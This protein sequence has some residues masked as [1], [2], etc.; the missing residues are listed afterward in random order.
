MLYF[1]TLKL[2]QVC[3]V[4]PGGATDNPTPSCGHSEI[5]SGQAPSD[6]GD[7]MKKILN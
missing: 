4:I 1:I 7:G 3:K 2:W 5:N 6:G